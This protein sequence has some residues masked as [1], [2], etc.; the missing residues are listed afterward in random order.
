MAEP[1]QSDLKENA[2][3][4]LRE[5]MQLRRRIETVITFCQE[6]V[7]EL[8][9]YAEFRTRERGDIYKDIADR[10]EVA[11]GVMMPKEPE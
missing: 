4:A 5:F 3:Q 9:G 11:L 10:L 1:R 7:T 8:H 2:A 6:Q